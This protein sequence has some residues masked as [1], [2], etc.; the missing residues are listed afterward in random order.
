MPPSKTPGSTRVASCAVLFGSLSSSSPS[1]SLVALWI[2]RL[3][4]P[5]PSALV[6]DKIF[7]LVNAI[8]DVPV[9]LP[10]PRETIAWEKAS[11]ILVKFVTTSTKKQKKT[12][13]KKKKKKKKCQEDGENEWTAALDKERRSNEE[14]SVV[15]AIMSVRLARIYKEDEKIRNRVRKRFERFANR[16]RKEGL[17]GLNFTAFRF[18]SSIKGDCTKPNLYELKLDGRVV[19]KSQQPGMCVLDLFVCTRSMCF[20]FIFN[21][22]CMHIHH[23]RNDLQYSELACDQV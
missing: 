17:K 13:K 21:A 2:L 15:E 4:S 16:K 14:A 11:K 19:R 18:D 20:S 12:K 7:E 8:D 1:A 3:Q 23:T 6:S 5:L 22:S 10:S 9:A